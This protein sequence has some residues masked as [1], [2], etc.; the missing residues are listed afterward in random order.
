MTLFI[1]DVKVRCRE[2]PVSQVHGNSALGDLNDDDDVI[3]VRAEV[4]NLHLRSRPFTRD[5]K[6]RQQQSHA[7]ERLLRPSVR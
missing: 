7:S 4:A 6:V 2:V 3:E 1:K 5:G